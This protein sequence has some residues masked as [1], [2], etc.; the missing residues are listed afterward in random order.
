M[1]EHKKFMEIS[2]MSS[3]W[4]EVPFLSLPNFKFTF[5]QH[6]P[7]D[8]TLSSHRVCDPIISQHVVETNCSR[9]VSKT[10][11]VVHG[12]FLNKFNRSRHIS[13]QS[14][15]EGICFEAPQWRLVS[16]TWDDPIGKETRRLDYQNDVV[17]GIRTCN[18]NSNLREII[19]ISLILCVK[20]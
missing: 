7:V 19:E 10:N 5:V 17:D 15:D 6:K 1:K 18:E 12:M 9:Q 14:G 16:A 4:M 11:H 3:P 8:V 2:K 13:K 20:K